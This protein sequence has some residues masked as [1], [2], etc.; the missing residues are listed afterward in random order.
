M[1]FDG[2]VETTAASCSP[3][4]LARTFA[5]MPDTAW[6]NVELTPAGGMQAIRDQLERLRDEDLDRP[7]RLRLAPGTYATRDAGQGEIYTDFEFDLI[8]SEGEMKTEKSGKKYRVQLDQD[9]RARIRG[10]GPEM[11]FKTWNGDI[12][13]RKHAR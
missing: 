5:L 7:V 1:P 9:V 3:E 6:T 13:I 10:G 2:K 8:P 4:G 11:H 12:F